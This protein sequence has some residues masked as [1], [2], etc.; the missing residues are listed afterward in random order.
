MEDFVINHI[1]KT[2]EFG[3]N[4]AKS[5]RTETKTDTAT[6]TPA[7]KASAKADVDTKELEN[8]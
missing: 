7:L 5:S 4:I 1:Q 3:N 8:E 6:W 2:H